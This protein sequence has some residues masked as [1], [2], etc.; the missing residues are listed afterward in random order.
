MHHGLFLFEYQCTCSEYPTSGLF[1]LDWQTGFRGEVDFSLLLVAFALLVC[2]R[3]LE[4]PGGVVCAEV[5]D[6]PLV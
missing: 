1:Q 5:K 4:W 2:R 3:Q 6:L